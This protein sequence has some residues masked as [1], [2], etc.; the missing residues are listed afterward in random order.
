MCTLLHSYNLKFK[1][2]QSPI[3]WNVDFAI[4]DER[5]N[6]GMREQSHELGA[7]ISKLRLANDEMSFKT[8]IQMEGEEV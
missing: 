1:F 4:V 7:F 8:Y 6:N 2:L 5:E 3:Q